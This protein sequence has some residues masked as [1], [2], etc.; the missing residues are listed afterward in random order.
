MGLIRY[1][2][3]CVKVVLCL[4]RAGVG[5]VVGVGEWP[6]LEHSPPS[7]FTFLNAPPSP[8]VT[9]TE[10]VTYSK[11]CNICNYHLY[12]IILN[13]YIETHLRKLWNTW[14]F[15]IWL[16]P[17]TNNNRCLFRLAEKN[18]YHS[19]LIIGKRNVELVHGFC[20]QYFTWN[21]WNE[22]R[23]RDRRRMQAKTKECGQKKWGQIKKAYLYLTPTFPQRS[24][25]PESVDELP[26][27]HNPAPLITLL[28]P[29]G[30]I[31]NKIA[32]FY[33][34]AQYSDSREPFAV[35]IFH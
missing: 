31:D 2:V 26:I 35:E 17:I 16:F 7:L 23:Q 28:P 34:I 14:I 21:C 18:K 9:K 25:L 29:E 13:S 12:K 3:T 24:L 30:V 11:I 6:V 5:H 33:K 4:R 19:H 32:Q 10:Q 8:P 20:A 1:R 15:T 27:K 22:M